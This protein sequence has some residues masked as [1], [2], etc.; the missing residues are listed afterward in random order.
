MVIYRGVDDN[1]FWSRPYVQFF[2]GRFEE[3]PAKPPEKLLHHI[4]TAAA[5]LAN[6]HHQLIAGNDMRPGIA[7]PESAAKEKE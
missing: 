2:D 5:A 1:K 7:P 4:I 3:I 6:W